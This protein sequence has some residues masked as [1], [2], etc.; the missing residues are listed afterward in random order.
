MRDERLRLADMR[1]ALAVIERY[2]S[3]G[4][5]RFLEQ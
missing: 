1:A 2:T 5:A 4:E 3:Q